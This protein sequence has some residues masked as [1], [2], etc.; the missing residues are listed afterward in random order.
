MDFSEILKI[1]NNSFDVVL[2]MDDDNNYL[3]VNLKDKPSIIITGS[4]GTSKSVLLNEIL[5]QLI[6]KNNS[7]DLKIVPIAPTKVE[8]KPYSETNYS[9]FNVV[10]DEKESLVI[11]EKVKDIITERKKLFLKNDVTNFEAYNKLKKDST[12]PFIVV[13]ID[14]ATNILNEYNSSDILF[15]IINNSK[16]CGVALVMNTNNVYNNFFEENINKLAACKISFDFVSNN[17]DKL[18]NLKDVHNLELGKFIVKI[19]NERGQNKYSV[20][21]FDDKYI[22]QILNINT[23]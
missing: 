16:E 12:L 21:K 17:E 1:K 5:L 13:A 11:L 6:S 9:Y 15:E 3:T 20:I 10:S 14:E 22:Y 8:L 18:I 7:D 23:K 19:G 4:T 2:G